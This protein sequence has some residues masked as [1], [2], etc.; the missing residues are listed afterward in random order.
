MLEFALVEHHGVEKRPAGPRTD[1][2]FIRRTG[3]LEQAQAHCSICRRLRTRCV[4]DDAK[5]ISGLRT[6]Y[7]YRFLFAPG[8]IGAITWLAR[9]ENRVHRIKYGLVVSMV[10]ERGGPTYKKSRR[11]NADIDRAIIHALNHSGLSP[12]IALRLVFSVLRDFRAV[13]SPVSS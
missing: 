13:R 7:S 8:T 12:T 11:G 5:R 6:R 2:G 4:L 1:L 10:G 3:G 9:N